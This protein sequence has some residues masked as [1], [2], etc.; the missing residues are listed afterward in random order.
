VAPLEVVAADSA[1]YGS[2]QRIPPFIRVAMYAQT[3]TC[4]AS[5]TSY[6]LADYGWDFYLTHVFEPEIGGTPGINA[7]SG[8]ANAEAQNSFAW[9]WRIHSSSSPAGSDVTNT[10]SFQCFK[11]D[12]AVNTTHAGWV[13]T[14]EK[15]YVGKSDQTVQQT[16]Y[17]AGSRACS[18]TSDNGVHLAD[19]N[20]LSQNG[21]ILR[22]T[23]GSA[24]Y[25]SSWK[26]IDQYYYTGTVQA[27]LAPPTPKTSYSRP[28]GK[29]SLGFTT[30][31]NGSD[32]AWTYV[33]DRFDTAS[34]SWKT[35]ATLAFTSSS[36]SVPTS[37]SY[38]TT[39]CQKY[40]VKATN[41]LGSSAYASFN[42][43][44]TICPG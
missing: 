40:R 7:D 2:N 8:T 23:S 38:A 43:G 28:S 41:P 35:I 22:G 14:A 39:K 17:L 37:Y 11:P 33:V 25:Q 19:K 29:V 26:D 24:C 18:D 21:S 5:G 34:N 20:N 6:S 42:N 1:K 9:Y 31:V 4:A 44:S 36:N 3:K 16:N 30:S 12:A 10:T 32:S 15:W 27:G 13:A